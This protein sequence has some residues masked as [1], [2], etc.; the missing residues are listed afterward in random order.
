MKMK[1]IVAKILFF[2]IVFLLLDTPIIAQQ[3][4]QQIK[5]NLEDVNRIINKAMIDSDYETILTYYTDDIVMM[6]NFSPALKG[7]DA[8]NDQYKK[9]KKNGVKI[10]SFTGTIEDLW[11]CGDHVYERGT[12]GLAAGSK[13][14]THPVA[15]YGSY[16]QIW[17][18]QQDDSYKI[19]FVIWNL[20]FNPFESVK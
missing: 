1:T 5:K 4:L 2:T 9:N 16:F 17:Q 10:F 12:Y 18:K 7:K 3:N 20:D 13:E 14:I 15:Y 6:P 11:I 19:K 8:I